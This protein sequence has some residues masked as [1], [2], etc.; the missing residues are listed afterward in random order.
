LL[1]VFLMCVFLFCL[2]TLA[3][4]LVV[5][6]LGLVEVA[7]GYR[8][9]R[10]EPL[11]TGVAFLTTVGGL[12]AM[13][14]NAYLALRAILGAF[15]RLLTASGAVRRTGRSVT[16]PVLQG[17]LAALGL[18]VFAF[19]C[20]GTAFVLTT[21][22][23]LAVVLTGQG[24]ERADEAVAFVF[25]FPMSLIAFTAL[26]LPGGAFVIARMRALRR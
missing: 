16:R 11:V 25:A 23:W 22:T 13:C 17:L 5:G 8:I 15:W 21:G 12:G 7:M 18:F 24:R 6:V 2:F 10:L 19:A 20:L 1:V 14:V 4:I 9:D 26:S 3:L